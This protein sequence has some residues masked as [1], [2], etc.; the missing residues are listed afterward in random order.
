M[1]DGNSS[2]FWLGGLNSSDGTFLFGSYIQVPFSSDTNTIRQK[3]VKNRDK[4]YF[5]DMGARFFS[6]FFVVNSSHNVEKVYN[7]TVYDT[8]NLFF[9]GYWSPFVV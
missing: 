8:V 1:M 6:T 9:S 7:L 3:I 5:I 2:H 4:Y